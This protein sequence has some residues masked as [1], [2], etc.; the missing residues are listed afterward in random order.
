MMMTRRGL[1]RIQPCS[2]LA[3]SSSGDRLATSQQNMM[4]PIGLARC[5]L[6]HIWDLTIMPTSMRIQPNAGVG[7]VPQDLLISG[8]GTKTKIQTIRLL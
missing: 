1:P 4:Q 7:K 3:F 5:A 2:G 8:Y 6:V